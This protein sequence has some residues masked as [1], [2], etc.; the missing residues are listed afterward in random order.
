M[1][2]RTAAAYKVVSHLPCIEIIAC[3]FIVKVVERFPTGER[4]RCHN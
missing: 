4:N 1:K 3:Y 2:T